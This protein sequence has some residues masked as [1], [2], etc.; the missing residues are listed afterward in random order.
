[1]AYNGFVMKG[2]TVVVSNEIYLKEGHMKKVV[3]LWC[4]ALLIGIAGQAAGNE[5]AGKGTLKVTINGFNNEKGDAKM[6]IFDSRESFRGGGAGIRGAALPIKAGKVEW[7]LT[8]L[9]FGTYAVK[10]FHDENGNGKVDKNSLGMPREQ[11]GFSNNARGS[12]GPP[13]YDKAAFTFSATN[14]AVTITVE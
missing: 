2:T 5:D 1:M 4:V 3:L 8:D 7:A 10:V 11:Y 13:D 6:T 9:P 14:T 12:F